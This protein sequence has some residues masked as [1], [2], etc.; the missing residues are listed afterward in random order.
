MAGYPYYPYSVILDIPK[1]PYAEN[2]SIPKRL[3]ESISDN[4]SKAFI[5]AIETAQLTIKSIENSQRA[6]YEK[7]KLA[8]PELVEHILSGR[9]VNYTKKNGIESSSFIV[10]EATQ[11]TSKIA[12]NMGR[13]R[14]RLETFT[15]Q[16]TEQILKLDYPVTGADLTQIISSIRANSDITKGIQQQFLTALKENEQEIL[17]LFV[18]FQKEEI[19][20]SKKQ[21]NSIKSILESVREELKK[22]RE[23]LLKMIKDSSKNYSIFE[24][25]AEKIIEQHKEDSNPYNTHYTEVA[26]ETIIALLQERVNKAKT[27]EDLEKLNFT[28][29]LENNTDV[30]ANNV[31]NARGY[32]AFEYIASLGNSLLSDE[33]KKKYAIEILRTGGDKTR[34]TKKLEYTIKVKDTNKKIHINQ[35]DYRGLV[36][37]P[38]FRTS[39]PDLQLQLKESE[40]MVENKQDDLIRFNINV[41]KENQ[42]RVAFSFSDKLISTFGFNDYGGLAAVKMEGGNL[43]SFITLLS[44]FP[45]ARPNLNDLIFLLLNLSTGSALSNIIEQGANLENFIRSIIISHIYLLAFNPDALKNINNL[46]SEI[47]SLNDNTVYFH[48]IDT[49]I[50]PSY[51]LL[52]RAYN[53]LE[54]MKN[55][56]ETINNA[57]FINISYSPSNFDPY[58]LY[59]TTLNS[60]PEKDQASQRW[61]MVSDSVAHDTLIKVALNIMALERTITA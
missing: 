16:I 12:K 29:R 31:R 22:S 41:G 19:L 38:F 21:Q 53:Q 52:S 24:K 8:E 46:N 9:N 48:H 47:K 40:T 43:F 10:D 32:E 5:Q 18:R 4:E 30:K 54:S 51:E 6:L 17:K 58:N 15:Q 45:S 56:S 50:I 27:F 3:S 36:N 49:G 59:A 55:M 25:L 13:Y 1:N 23:E 37:S 39:F 28:F 26:K 34:V 44:N 20:I 7:I 14:D 2:P 35:E 61:K 11:I 57:N 33:E 42:E 60:Y